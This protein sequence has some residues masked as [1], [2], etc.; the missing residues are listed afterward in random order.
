[1]KIASLPNKEELCDS[2][3]NLLDYISKMNNFPP[4]IKWSDIEDT[5]ENDFLNTKFR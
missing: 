4:I 3:R 2:I 1:M 5:I